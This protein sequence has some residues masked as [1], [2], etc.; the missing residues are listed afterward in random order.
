MTS[1]GIDKWAKDSIGEL[2]FIK[3]NASVGSF[4]RALQL[5]VHSSII[6]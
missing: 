6:L 2:G 5:L 1:V 3:A 4:T